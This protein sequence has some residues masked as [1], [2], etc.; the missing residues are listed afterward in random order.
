MKFL[1]NKGR[2]HP[3]HINP[4]ERTESH[5]SHPVLNSEV[6]CNE[7]LAE[8]KGTQSFT[9]KGGFAVFVFALCLLAASAMP[10]EQQDME[11]GNKIEKE[12]VKRGGTECGRGYRGCPPMLYCKNGYCVRT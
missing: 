4:F 8:F 11:D 7:A 5:T 3:F 10:Y 1:P 2:K 12:P 9:M 6:T